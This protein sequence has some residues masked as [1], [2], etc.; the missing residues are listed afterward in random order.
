MAVGEKSATFPLRLVKGLAGDTPV[1]ARSG[2]VIDDDAL[3]RA[4]Q[5]GDMKIASAF[6]DRLSPQVNR[7]IRRLLG[8]V[9]CDHDD[10]AQIA[11]IEL[12]KTIGRYRGECSLDRWAQTVTAHAVFKH[13]RRRNIERR[14]FT[15][16]LAEDVYA[17]PFNL[18]RRAIVRG[19]LERI[20]NHL[21]EL[22]E[23]RAWAFILHDGLGYDLQ[24]VAEM[25]GTSVAA[26]QSRLV[27]GRRD[28]HARIARDPELVDLM[29]VERQEDG[30]AER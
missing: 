1:V 5:A 19:L 21:D 18:D 20:A 22:S 7:T 15:G 24:E 6:C 2:Q 8:R 9:D 14:I 12:V 4:V 28:L 11:L 10:I 17:G 3:V 27:R 23:P 25:T 16:L 13:I 26:A 29:R 30:E